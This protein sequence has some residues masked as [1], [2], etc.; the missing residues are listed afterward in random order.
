MSVFESEP[1]EPLTG[2]GTSFAEFRRA[3]F[4]TDGLRIVVRDDRVDKTGEVRTHSVA[5][6]LSY[7]EA[8]ALRDWL[9]EWLVENWPQEEDNE[10][11]A[12]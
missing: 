3:L 7:D 10:T 1:Y 9:D 6:Y 4:R 5:A 2:I 11:T 12:D 8:E